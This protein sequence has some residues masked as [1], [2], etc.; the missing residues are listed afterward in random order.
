MKRSALTSPGV[1]K[2]PTPMVIVKEFLNHAVMY[3]L[4]AYVDNPQ[5]M[6]FIRSSIMESMLVIFHQEGLEILSP[7]FHI[8]REG[9][10][11][12]SEILLR[13]SIVEKEIDDTAATG[14]TMFDSLEDNGN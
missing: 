1:L 9:D 7:L 10:C 12:S 6:L 8:K 4:R 11:P 14:L 2:E 13:R 3:R 5:N